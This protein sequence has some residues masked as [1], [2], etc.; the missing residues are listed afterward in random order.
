MITYVLDQVHVYT[1][2]V[3]FTAETFCC[4]LNIF[5]Q[6][7]FLTKIKHTTYFVAIHNTYVHGAGTTHTNFYSSFI[8]RIIID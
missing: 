7:L 2:Y 8:M 6:R 3:A 5:R 1:G 4:L